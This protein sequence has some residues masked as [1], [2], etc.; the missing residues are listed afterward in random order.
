MPYLGGLVSFASYLNSLPKVLGFT[1]TV[2]AAVLHGNCTLTKLS[3]GLFR[4]SATGF[5]RNATPH[6]SRT[7]CRHLFWLPSLCTC[8]YFLP[9]GYSR[10]P[11]PRWTGES[12]R[13]WPSPAKLARPRN[14]SVCIA[15]LARVQS[16][17][18]GMRLLNSFPR[19]LAH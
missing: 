19:V 2:F 9:S 18:F 13:C 10:R 14:K 6:S 12:E 3:R 15:I 17:R 7:R 8:R 1:P 16:I 5:L 4:Y 11:K